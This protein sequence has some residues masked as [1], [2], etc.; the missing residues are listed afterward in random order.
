M[1][2]LHRTVVL[3]LL[4][5]GATPVTAAE[6]LGRL[7]MTPEQRAALDAAREPGNEL[8]TDPAQPAT[9][10]AISPDA[11]VLLNGVI[12][13]SRG[14]NVAWVNG[15]RASTSGDDAIHVSRGPDRH[16]RVTLEEGGGT[17]AQLKP[18]QFWIPATGQVADCYGCAAVSK[19]AVPVETLPSTTAGT[20]AATPPAAP[21]AAPP[22][23][24]P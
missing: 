16:N 8:L 7:F 10:R 18:G 13:R 17:K 4:G 3:V 11:P 23:T 24:P 1:W 19:P 5:L 21:L 9:S 22:A 2:I 15:T 6:P 20:S 14:P 12:R